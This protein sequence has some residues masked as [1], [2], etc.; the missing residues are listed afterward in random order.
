MDTTY[1]ADWFWKEKIFWIFIITVIII[2]IFAFIIAKV[3]KWIDDINS[4]S[5]SIR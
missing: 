3:G 2:Y 5:C 1:E 4:T